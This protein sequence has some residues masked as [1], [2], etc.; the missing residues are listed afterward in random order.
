VIEQTDQFQKFGKNVAQKIKIKKNKKS[1]FFLIKKI[2]FF[3]PSV[4]CRTV[5][6]KLR[7]V[8]QTRLVDAF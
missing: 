3:Q 1:D 7:P 8:G 4:H 2:I 5:M 6:G